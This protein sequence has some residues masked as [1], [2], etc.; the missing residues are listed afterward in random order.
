M[1]SPTAVADALHAELAARRKHQRERHERARLGEY[2]RDVG[3][4]CKECGPVNPLVAEHG[5]LRGF[6]PVVFKVPAG[7]TGTTEDQEKVGHRPCFTCN[8]DR[9]EAWQR[10]DMASKP[11]KGETAADRQAKE[12]KRRAQEEAS[13]V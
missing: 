7:L 5:E 12:Q 13:W 4:T 11:A 9:W 3:N 8:P 6:V 1:S 10:G 2:D